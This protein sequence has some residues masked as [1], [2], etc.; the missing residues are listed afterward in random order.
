MWKLDH[1]WQNNEEGKDLYETCFNINVR[2]KRV[3]SEALKA[4]VYEISAYL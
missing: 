1:H 2:V 4:K 3:P